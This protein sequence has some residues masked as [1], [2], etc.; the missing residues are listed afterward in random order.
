MFRDGAPYF[1]RVFAICQDRA[2]VMFSELR[3]E[4]ASLVRREQGGALQ[5]VVMNDARLPWHRLLRVCAGLFDVLA[6]FD[7]P[8]AM[9]YGDLTM[10][11]VGYGDDDTVALLDARWAPN[12]GF[13]AMEASETVA[14]AQ[15]QWDL[16]PERVI[17]IMLGWSSS[18]PL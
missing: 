13:L 11:Q 5:L 15:R 3:S 14:K 18:R 17:T 6:Y 1:P 8:P 4:L 7:R 9:L 10:R 16:T 2:S 12:F